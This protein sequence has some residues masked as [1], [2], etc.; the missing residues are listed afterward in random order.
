MPET[1]LDELTF[2]VE[3]C[4]SSYPKW[5]NTS[6]IHRQECMFRLQQLIRRDMKK[7][8]ENI[9]YEQGKTLPDAE[10]D[11]VRGLQVFNDIFAK[12][13]NVF[14]WLNKLAEQ[15][16]FCLEKICLSEFE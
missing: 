2:S 3:S 15:Q 10:G 9:T 13:C 12:M 5:K 11:V 4:K 8:A 16:P 7:L 14:R 6:V 1:T